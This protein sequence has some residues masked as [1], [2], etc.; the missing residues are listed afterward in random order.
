MQHPVEDAKQNYDDLVFDAFAFS[1]FLASAC[2][3]L[4][5]HLLGGHDGR[6][7]EGQFCHQEARERQILQPQVRSIFSRFFENKK[8][9]CCSSLQYAPRSEVLREDEIHVLR[10]W[11]I[12][13]GYHL[14]GNF[15]NAL[16]SNRHERYLRLLLQETRDFGGD[17]A[18]GYGHCGGTRPQGG[19]GIL[20]TALQGAEGMLMEHE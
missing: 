17:Q 18:R 14:N 10:G 2:G 8:N 5:R 9:E 4:R 6:A 12:E 20:R 13:D 3:R 11:M 15:V 19:M 7:E 1:P 16:V